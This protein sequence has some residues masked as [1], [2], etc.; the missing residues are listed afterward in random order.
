M[1]QKF[2]NDISKMQIETS[3]AAASRISEQWSG[4]NQ[5]RPI[6]GAS[7]IE[8]KNLNESLSSEAQRATKNKNNIYSFGVLKTV[9]ALKNSSL[10]EINSAKIVLER[11]ENLLLNKNVPEAFLVESLL[12]ELKGFEWEDSAK[13]AIENLRK[14]FE[15][16]RREIEVA[17]AYQTIKNSP[18]RELFSDATDS[19]S[20]WLV[21]ENRDSNVLSS[22][23]RRWGF[24]PVVR[25]LVNFLG[26]HESHN[27]KS[28]HIKSD[29][30]LSVVSNIYSPL[31]VE[32]DRSV[33]YTSGRYFSV[34][35]NSLNVLSEAET[36][37]L[38]KEFTDKIVLINDPMVR[39]ADNKVSCS[40]GKNRVDFVYENETKK[41][42]F[43]G[44]EIK[45]EDLAK[46]LNMNIHNIFEGSNQIINK[47]IGI[48]KVSDELMEIDFGK[49][50]S[51]RIYENAEA[52]IFKIKNKIYVQTVNPSMK[53]NT[54][55]EGN[56]T[57]ASNI[58]KEFIKFD[59][60]ESLTEFLDKENA[61]RSV[62]YNDRDQISKNI[63]ILENEIKKI[64]AAEQKNPLLKGSQELSSI[65]ESIE[66]E[67]ESL[68]EKWNII[69]F[70]IKRFE[71]QKKEISQDVSENIGYPLETEVRV[72]KNGTKGKIIGVDGSSKT[73]TIMMENGT[74]SEYFFGDV[75]N[76]EDE[77]YRTLPDTNEGLSM[78]NAPIGGT[79]KTKK[80]SK[81]H[82]K[83]K[84]L[85]AKA[86]GSSAK[87]PSKFMEND[88]NHNL[89]DVTKVKKSGKILNTKGVGNQNL[90]SAPSKKSGKSGSKFI[91]DLG[92][93]NL[94]KAPS[95]GIKNA[96]KFIDDLKNHKLSLSE[97]QKNK[98]I[99]K[100]PNPKSK[101]DG[102]KFMEDM[103]NA[104]LAAPHGNSR[105]NGKKFVEDL[106]RAGLSSAPG[107]K[108]SK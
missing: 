57:Q 23:L 82:N 16:R 85:M 76:L 93:H 27:G 77:V 45:E 78:A 24:N 103:K 101:G 67:I 44:K 75:E 48:S 94:S 8:N 28:V 1:E 96:S 64:E 15:K 36:R 29:N 87:S 52:N 100:A 7:F 62:M 60:S 18:G 12:N 73:Y 2:S 86:P 49:K 97:S 42:F 84:S 58:I 71:S 98:S 106:K 61:V 41:V 55:Y 79:K 10:M 74:T 30:S 95:P 4:I 3:K 70:E 90:S 40:F 25:G 92:I 99:E 91:Q 31:L 53:T 6:N 19:M 81:I 54:V 22:E 51:S 104:G 13:N 66:N 105:K 59:V 21:S 35:E 80:D 65:R 9:M 14:V 47:I 43:N 56:A 26:E 89:S 83:S 88:K 107:S 32:E 20:K 5:P 37:T 39:I 33:F 17:K 68:R 108:K 34:T 72:I 69:N 38:P 50:I 46:S 11:F 102:K 63:G